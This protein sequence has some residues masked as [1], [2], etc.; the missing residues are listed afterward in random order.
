MSRLFEVPTC[1]RHKVPFAVVTSDSG[2]VEIR[3]PEGCRPDTDAVESRV[4]KTHSLPKPMEPARLWGSQV[5]L[6]VPSFAVQ[7][8]DSPPAPDSDGE[9]EQDDLPGGEGFRPFDVGLLPEPLARFTDEASRSI[10]CDASF[11]ALPLLTSCAAAIGNSRCLAVKAGWIVPAILWTVVVGESGTAKSP[12]IRLAISGIRRLEDRWELEYQAEVARYEELVARDEAPPHAPARKRLL[13]NDTSFEAIAVLLSENPRGLF[14]ANDELASWFGSFD[15][16]S[17]GKGGAEA[18]RYLPMH[19]AEPLSVDRKVGTVRTVGVPAA[20]LSVT[21]GIQPGILRRV[22]S[23]QH[24]ES[25]MAARFLVAYPPR[26]PKRWTDEEVSESAI[27][28]VEALIARLH[29][30]RPGGTGGRNAPQAIRMSDDARQEYRDFCDRHGAEQV[31][32]SGDLASAWSK[33]E[34]AAARLALVVH[35]VRSEAGDSESLLLDVESMRMGIRLTEWFKA[36]ARRIYAFFNES[37]EEGRTRQ[38]V[39]WVER[40]GGR[41]TPREVQQGCRWLKGPGVARATL[42]RLVSAGQGEW[43]SQG[44]GRAKDVFSL[45]RRSGDHLRHTSRNE[46]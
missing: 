46:Q 22:F 20:S 19:G 45:R 9:T 41:C 24:R 11:V 10:G 18:S 12:S 2:E 3:C 15:R 36:E 16:H 23:S 14:L 43:M 17:A 40:R 37:A 26:R 8:P 25:G 44:V 35:C 31:D 34:E 27:A 7:A 39:D 28:D 13:V 6:M 38:L 32:L 21:G 33:L 42:D 30:L 5:E 4:R 29:E 1:R